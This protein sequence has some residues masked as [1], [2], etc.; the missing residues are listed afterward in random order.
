M[1]SQT[2][3]QEA[4][5]IAQQYG[6]P[7]PLFLAQ[8]QQESS[9]NPNAQNGNAFG[10][11]QMMPATATDY[12]VD[13]S[14]P[15]TELQA[16]AAYDADL[17]SGNASGVLPASQ[18]AGSWLN[19]MISYGTLPQNAVE[20]YNAGTLGEGQSNV[21]KLTTQSIVP[22]GVT[23]SDFS[24]SSNILNAIGYGVT[25]PENP[26]S[27]ITSWLSGKLANGGFMIVGA[28]LTIGA[29]LISQRANVEKAVG[30]VTRAVR[31]P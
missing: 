11:G 2:L 17:Y 22:Q 21:L 24:T 18:S 10:L 13:P 4:A 23:A 14:N 16:A 15:T 26:A 6:I 3:Q 30:T 25:H 29:L 19:T 5:Q 1:S 12:G 9:F 20:S 27:P 31:L 8:I 7:V 28:I